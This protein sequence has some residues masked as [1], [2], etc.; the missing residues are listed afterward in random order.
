VLRQL[1]RA[2]HV[3]FLE[4]RGQTRNELMARGAARADAEEEASR[5]AFAV[6]DVGA[7]LGAATRCVLE[8][9]PEAEVHAIDLWALGARY[10]SEQLS[11]F[12]HAALAAE[13]AREPEPFARFCEALPPGAEGRARVFPLTYPA[14]G[15]LALLHHN[16]VVPWVVWLDADLQA[17][18]LRQQLDALWRFGWADPAADV[19]SAAHRRRPGAAG[20]AAVTL[21]GGGGWDLSEG[22]R[23]AVLDF[24]AEH[25]LPLHVEEGRAWT[26]CREAVRETRNDPANPLH[27]AGLPL[28]VDAEAA[29]RQQAAASAGEQG[30]ALGA[31]EVFDGCVGGPACGDDA[32]GSRAAPQKA[33]ARVT[34][35]GL[36]TRANRCSHAASCV[37]AP[38]PC[39]GR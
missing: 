4:L 3:R 28:G 15:G 30:R 20:A 35:D 22:V 26:F 5:A 1:V 39:A 11:L 36:F 25:A 21:V 27:A 23:R 24:A 19:P 14:T 17:A 18:P 33:Y 37:A 16:E 10:Y 7:G 6:A 2:A 29:A 8:A 38:S 32:A 34:G 13:W 12:G 9:A 31:M